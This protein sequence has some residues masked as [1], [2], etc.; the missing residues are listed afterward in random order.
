MYQLVNIIANKVHSQLYTGYINLTV[1]DFLFTHKYENNILYNILWK[2]EQM[3]NGK[4]FTL[5]LRMF[6][7]V[8][9]RVTISY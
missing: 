3:L 6:I 9:T 4:Q 2:Y 5:N 7:V 1:N 8:Q